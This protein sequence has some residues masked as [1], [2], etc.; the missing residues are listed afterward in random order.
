[1]SDRKGTRAV[2]YARYF[3]DMQREESIGENAGS[4]NCYGVFPANPAR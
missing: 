1:M 3:T 2:I 4:G